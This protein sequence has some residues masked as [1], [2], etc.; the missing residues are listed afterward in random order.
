[1]Q[2]TCRCHYIFDDSRSAENW[3]QKKNRL[4]TDE[5]VA[6][7]ERGWTSETIKKRKA[8]EIASISGSN[9]AEVPR[10]VGL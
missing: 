2:W 4:L 8:K 3:F 9:A 7:S 1:M 5:I 10:S 6:R